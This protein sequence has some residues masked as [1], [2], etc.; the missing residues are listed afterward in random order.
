[1]S[2]HRKWTSKLP[3]TQPIFIIIIIIVIIVTVIIIATSSNHLLSIDLWPPWPPSH[4]HSFS[5]M[6]LLMFTTSLETVFWLPTVLEAQIAC[7]I[8]WNLAWPIS[9]QFYFILFTYLFDRVAYGILVPQPGMEPVP[10]ALGAWSLN[11]WTTREVS[12]ASFD[13]LSSYPLPPSPTS[14]HRLSLSR[15]FPHL[16]HSMAPH[17]I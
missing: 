14:F 5:F 8:L 9:C 4:V 7:H 6:S 2:S 3:D 13:S 1:M 15:S 11:P 12:P 17:C 16:K 10:P